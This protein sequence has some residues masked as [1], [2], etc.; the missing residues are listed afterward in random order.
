MTEERV[1]SVKLNKLNSSTQCSAATKSSLTDLARVHITKTKSP[2]S[3]SKA[4]T[5]AQTP[6]TIVPRK[7]HRRP[8]QMP[9]RRHSS[10]SSRMLAARHPCM[11][12]TSLKF[13][14]TNL[15]SSMDILCQLRP[16]LCYTH[17]SKA[18]S[19]I[20]SD[21]SLRQDRMIPTSR[22]RTGKRARVSLREGTQRSC[23]PSASISKLSPKSHNN[24]TR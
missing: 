18:N 14:V 22:L 9:N 3:P 16:L 20:N 17:C 6:S 7:S 19:T 23:K 2:A 15:S 8:Q 21:R 1:K 5:L 11:P 13:L 4:L 12:N 24:N 10:S